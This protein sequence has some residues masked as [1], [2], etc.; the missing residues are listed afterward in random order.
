MFIPVGTQIEFRLTDDKGAVIG[1]NRINPPI[2]D[3]LHQIRLDELSVQLSPDVSYR[4][5]VMVDEKQLGKA[6]NPYSSVGIRFAG[7]SV[8]FDREKIASEDNLV[9]AQIYARNGYWYDAF[10]KL[11]DLIKA[12]L[13][14]C[15]LVKL[16]SSLLEGGMVNLDVVAQAL[17]E[18]AGCS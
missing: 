12:Y 3:G 9:K 10:M 8:G 1:S 18:Q 11:T 4:W 15:K 6:K 2:I 7:N 14:N 16:R 13:G 5:P 17:I